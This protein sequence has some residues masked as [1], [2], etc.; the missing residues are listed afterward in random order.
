MRYCRQIGIAE[1][2]VEDMVPSPLRLG[3]CLPI[4]P[5]KSLKTTRKV[6]L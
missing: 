3:A 1:L 4:E 2:G 6:Q 5:L